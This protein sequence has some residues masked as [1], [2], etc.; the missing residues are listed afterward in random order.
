MNVRLPHLAA[1]GFFAVMLL[2]GTATTD[3]LAGEPD[4]IAEIRALYARANKLIDVKEVQVELLASDL[5]GKEW[6]FLADMKARGR[7]DDVLVTAY[8]YDGK[9]F[10]LDEEGGNG[11]AG[12]ETQYFFYDNGN[13]AFEFRRLETIFAGCGNGSRESKTVDG[14]LE[15]FG[16]SETRT[17]YDREGREIKQLKKTFWP[18]TGKPLEC[19]F[20][21]SGLDKTSV[22]DIPNKTPYYDMLM[23]HA[24]ASKKPGATPSP[25][26][27]PDRHSN[28]EEAGSDGQ[29]K[30]NQ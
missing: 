26:H 19:I 6:R 17:Y 12:V 8:W 16:V 1:S 29:P 13:V 5:Y 28:G 14:V 4:A 7:D 27:Q 15:S 11:D 20:D 3:G 30:D 9:L 18:K 10:R 22:S 2:L 24:P 21:P 23:A 25:P